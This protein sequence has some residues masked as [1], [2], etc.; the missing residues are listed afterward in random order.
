MPCLKSFSDS[1][2]CEEVRQSALC[3]ENL[4]LSEVPESRRHCV[5]IWLITSLISEYFFSSTECPEK[6]SCMYIPKQLPCNMGIS[7]C[8][9]L[10]PD[11]GFFLFIG[12][13]PLAGVGFTCGCKTLKIHTVLLF[14]SHS[15]KMCELCQIMLPLYQHY[16][17]ISCVSIAFSCL[18]Y[19][20]LFYIIYP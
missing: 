9:L 8:C 3:Y 18:S 4:S 14:F 12:E 16:C 20:L 15:G 11:L 1:I 6:Y 19:R 2:P 5:G 10:N 13:S 7:S 17:F